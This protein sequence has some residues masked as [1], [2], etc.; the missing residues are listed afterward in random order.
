MEDY[1]VRKEFIGGRDWGT[2][3][4]LLGRRWELSSFEMM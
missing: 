3:I 4:Y 2:E 1:F